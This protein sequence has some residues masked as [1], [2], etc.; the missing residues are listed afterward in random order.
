VVLLVEWLEPLGT[1]TPAPVIALRLFLA[2]ALGAAIGLEREYKERPAGLRTHMLTAVASTV[3]TLITLELLSEAR[4][5]TGSASAD[6]IR[7]IEAVTAGVAFLAAG[8]IIRARGQVRGL[9]TGAGMWLAGAVGVACG[10][11]YYSIAV[12]ATLLA[13]LIL[14]V[15]GRLEDASV[16]NEEDDNDGASSD[17]DRKG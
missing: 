14:A 16:P 7:V 3:F 17:R 6:P 5:L 9:T 10:S 4:S 1:S 2:T 12:M 13:L 11:G 15:V 8:A